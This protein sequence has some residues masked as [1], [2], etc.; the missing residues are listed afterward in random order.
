MVVIEN[1]IGSGLPKGSLRVMR[2]KSKARILSIDTC[3]CFLT[4][5]GADPD[6]GDYVAV[7]YAQIAEV[8]ENLISDVAV[9]DIGVALQ[10]YLGMLRRYVVP[11][12]E[13]KELAL[14]IYERHREALNFILECRPEPES[15]L[16]MIRDLVKKSENLVPDRQVNSTARFVPQAWTNIAALNACPQ[17]EWTKTGRNVIFEVKSFRVGD[18]DRVALSLVLGPSTT[19]MR[20]HFFSRA[21]SSPKVFSHGVRSSIGKKWTTLFSRELL[22]KNASVNM[23]EEQKAAAISKAWGMFVEHDL[24][25]LSAI[26]VEFAASAPLGATKGS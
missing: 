2:T 20:E 18:S 12:E 17:G 3:S 10:H 4:P 23:S 7:S 8:I 1:K 9:G 15:W 21:R 13:L 22:S 25:K 11:D 14:R 16:G 26:M 5:D 24:P 19:A 6:H